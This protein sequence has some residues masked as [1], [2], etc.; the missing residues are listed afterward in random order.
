MVLMVQINHRRKG[1]AVCH[2]SH[3]R[4]LTR[5]GVDTNTIEQVGT[6]GAIALMDDRKEM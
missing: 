2:L 5:H 1:K 4:L 6:G 3:L